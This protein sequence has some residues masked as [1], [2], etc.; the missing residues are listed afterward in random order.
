MSRDA[1]ATDSVVHHEDR[2]LAQRAVARDAEA[3]EAYARR[4]TCVP[5]MVGALNRRMAARLTPEQVADLSQDVIVLAWR[6]LDT[7]EGRASLESWIHRFV[8]F[9]IRNVLRRRD[10]RREVLSDQLETLAEEKVETHSPE[11]YAFLSQSLDEL[12]PP[13]GDVVR[14]KHYEHLT[15]DAIGERLGIPANTAKTHYYRS[16]QRLRRKLAPRLEGEFP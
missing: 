3:L 10:R 6:K 13:S 8:F 14:L 7:F 15:F 2:E 16:L 9:E 12:E 11:A 1:D 5:R 4:M